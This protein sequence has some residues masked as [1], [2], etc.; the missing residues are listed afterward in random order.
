MTGEKK[1]EKGIIIVMHHNCY[2]HISFSFPKQ[3]RERARQKMIAGVYNP[4]IAID[5]HIFRY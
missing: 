4:I 5:A 2:Y 1:K 3:N